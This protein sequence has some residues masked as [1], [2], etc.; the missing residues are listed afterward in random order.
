M[1][2]RGGIWRG[3]HPMVANILAAAI[4]VLL[5][6]IWVPGMLRDDLPVPIAVRYGNGRLYHFHGTAAWL[7]FA[8][9]FL[10]AASIMIAIVRR[11]KAKP[12]GKT[13][14]RLAIII[15]LAGAFTISTM[16]ILKLLGLV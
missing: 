2:A 1:K 13:D 3:R 4:A 8:G 11:L 12:G 10:L 15:G 14:Q 16:T 9:F 7:L 5:V 6:G